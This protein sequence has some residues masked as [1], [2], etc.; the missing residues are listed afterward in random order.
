M[1][2]SY[3]VGGMTCGGCARS[4]ENAIKGLTPGATI[5][6]DLPTGKVTVENGPDD[7]QVEQAVKDA[8]FDYKGK[9][10]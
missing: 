7:T 4:V 5:S 8:G 3:S 2:K 6:I 9:A 10:A 1:A